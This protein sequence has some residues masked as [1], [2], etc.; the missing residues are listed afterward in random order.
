MA[1]FSERGGYK[2]MPSKMVP[3]SMTVELRS[4]LWNAIDTAISHDQLSKITFAL[5][6]DLYKKPVDTRPLYSGYNGTSYDKSWKVVREI[7]FAESWAGAYD[8]IEFFVQRRL[9]SGDLINSILAQEFAAYRILKGQVCQ[10]TDDLEI[11]QVEDMLKL[12]GIFKP[13]ADHIATAL[14]RLSDRGNP[15]YRNSIKESILAVESMARLVTGEEKATLGKVLNKLEQ[16]GR[17]NAALKT[18]FSSIYGWSSDTNGIRH[19][20]TDVSVVDQADAK[21]YLI[22]CCAFVNYLKVA[23]GR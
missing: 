21:F 7:Y 17:I 22:A 19:A 8:H 1:T 23:G 6:N 10:I 16:D 15:D 2:T 14:A 13:V 18:G 11:A 3:E 20:M 12:G 9:V 4:L 5:W